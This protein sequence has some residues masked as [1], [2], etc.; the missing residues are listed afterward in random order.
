MSS[1]LPP[2][3]VLFLALS[4]IGNLLMQLPAIE[5][6]KKA[7][8]E[9]NVIVWV[10][11]RGTKAL[12]EATKAI[13]VVI[14]AKPQRSLFRHI[15]LTARFARL[16]PE[17]AIMLSPGQLIKGAAY[18]FLSGA[19]ARVAHA[20]PYLGNPASRFLLTHSVSEQAGRHDIE[21]NLHLLEPL[22]IS[23]QAAMNQPYRFTPAA[24]SQARANKSIEALQL[25]PQRLLIGLHAGSA[26]DFL[27]K[28]W[29]LEHFAAVARQLI[30]DHQAHILLF[31]GPDEKKQNED[32]QTL[33]GP[34]HSSIIATDLVTTAAIMTHCRLFLAN[35]SGLMHLA[36]AV[37]V[38][39]FGLFG[40]TDERSTGPRG[41]DSHVIRAAGTEPAYTT[42]SGAALGSA[43]HKT[44]LKITPAIVLD[45]IARTARLSAP[46]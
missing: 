8:P 25:L 3:N 39:T 14:E 21:Q 5:T 12:A 11:P 34:R 40:P 28:R 36:A 29:P 18:M 24:E 23:I 4:G 10:A 31:G 43:P 38:P 32:L 35:D 16:K 9:A 1:N 42:E 45:K 7:W 17:V 46:G 6:L 20:Y 33:I 19:E 26:P 15:Q 30:A 27:W 41:H 22:G 37:G 13:N 44:L 2:K